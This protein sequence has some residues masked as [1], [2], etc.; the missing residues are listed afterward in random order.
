MAAASFVPTTG[1]GGAPSKYYTYAPGKAP[2]G[3]GA[4]EIKLAPGETLHY[5]EG[6]GY[7]SG[8]SGL[9]AVGVTGTPPYAVTNPPPARG[10]TPSKKVVVKAPAGPVSPYAPLTPGAVDAQAS[11]EAQSQLTPQQDEIRRQ[12]AAAAAQATADEQAIQGFQTAA[13][14]LIQGIAPGVGD[15]YQ[16]AAAEEGQLGQGM[17]TGVQ[18]DLAA[19]SA[20]D[21]AFAASQGQET[22]DTTSPGQAHDVLYGLNGQIP[23]DNLSEQGAAAQTLAIQQSVLPLDAGREQ[24]DARMAQARQSNDQ[25]AQ[26]LIQLATTYP[27]LKAQALQQLNQYELDKATYRMN[28][29]NEQQD[30]ARQNRALT[31]SENAAKVVK[32]NGGLTPAQVQEFKYKYAS[33]NFQ[34]AKAAA[35]A[36]AAAKAGKTINVG[37]SRLMGHIV[38]KDGTQDPSIKVAQTAASNPQQKAVV[39]RGKATQKASVDAYKY[40]QTLLGKPVVNKQPGLLTGKGKFVAAP[41][42]ANIPPGKPGAVYHTTWT[43]HGPRPANDVATTDKL[44]RSSHSGTAGSYADA[45]MKVW[46]EIGGD[47]LMARYG[48]S[49]QQV[50][51]IVNKALGAAGWKK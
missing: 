36:Q 3:Q 48:Y 20:A 6:K 21:T 29:N 5:A 46:A 19:K 27:G 45:Q 10:G 25:Y 41:Q 31:D 35:A 7:Y 18:N 13:S 12:Q 16:H 14:G 8:P 37:A 43:G 2:K 47:S 51:T 23:G 40:A 39:N 4:N 42:F 9:P 26:Q 15:A 17:A 33:L 44:G 22:Q 30:N 1:S 28:L 34:T 32:A 38:Y 24:L 50:M 49:K 11:A